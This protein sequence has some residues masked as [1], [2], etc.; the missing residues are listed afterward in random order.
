MLAR[1]QR[2]QTPFGPLALKIHPNRYVPIGGPPNGGS[3][4]GSPLNQSK[5]WSQHT[6]TYKYKSSWLRTHSPK[7]HP[8][9]E[10]VNKP[11][12]DH[13]SLAGNGLSFVVSD[14]LALVN[15][16]IPSCKFTR[17]WKNASTTSDWPP[18]ECSTVQTCEMLLSRGKKWCFRRDEGAFC[19]PEL[20]AAQRGYI[21]P[22]MGTV[23]LFGW[24][25]RE[26]K[27]KPRHF[28]GL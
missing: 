25:S 26:T 28:A 1:N 12:Q 22:N 27:W 21:D 9:G 11:C 5:G 7:Q 10:G 13:K 18:G 23:P 16:P 4:F 2:E 15:E 20:E 19:R 14:K 17:S 24:L 6:H 3:P 8:R